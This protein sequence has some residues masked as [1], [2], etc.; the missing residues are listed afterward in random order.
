[1]DANGLL[2]VLAILVAG[3]SLLSDEKRLDIR[4]R[5]SWLDWL[6]LGLS[7]LFVL[8]IIY[9]PVIKSF[10]L[11]VPLPWMFGFNEETTTF[12]VLVFII[13]FFG[14]KVLGKKLSKTK[15]HAWKYVSDRLLRE[16]K[17]S[18]LAYL[19]EK[20]HMQLIKWI[21]HDVWYVNLHRFIQPKL[22]P[23]I[24]MMAGKEKRPLSDSLRI[25]LA[26]LVPDHSNMQDIIK[27]SISRILKSKSFVAY[28]AETHPMVAARFTSVRF[29]DDDEFITIYFEAL[30]SHP[31]SA[32]YR[33]LRD[34]QNCSYTGEYYL[35]ESNSLL[36]YYL[37]NVDMACNLSIWQPI[38][39]YVIVFIQNQKGK[40][41]IYNQPCDRFSDGDERWSC[42]I[43]I[44][45]LFFT[46]MVSLA[47]FQRKK[48]HMWLMYCDNFIEEILKNLDHSP[49]VDKNREF[50]SRFDYLLYVIFSACDKWVG[51][52]KYID[53]KD[54]KEEDRKYF[55]EYWAAK[56]LGSMLRKLIKSDKLSDSQKSYFLTIAIRRMKSLDQSCHDRYSKLIIN[57]CIRE[58]EHDAVDKDT[59]DLLEEVYRQVDH[60][61]KSDES[62]FERLITKFNK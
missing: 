30:I 15:L 32:L 24:I 58:Y 43:F 14:N 11:F 55:T 29:R 9:M 5:I 39:E 56:T 4:L 19:L 51:A 61:L 35:D 37:K 3:Y 25:G 21:R 45:S 22:I 36:N 2:T 1:M 13:F 49:E 53:Y 10:E 20:Y 62:T 48:D 6:I 59:I 16:K 60:V 38:A 31:E 18:E 40:D 26:K 57:N 8:I 33:E 12:A 52:V 23:T 50:P 41:N 42:P 46:V 7:I 47:I 34:N 54:V 27:M 44:G 28:L 17:F